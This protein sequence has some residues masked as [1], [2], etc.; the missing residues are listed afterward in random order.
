MSNKK[1]Q[2]IPTIKVTLI[3]KESKLKVLHI[4]TKVIHD[5]ETLRAALNRLGVMDYEIVCWV[6]EVLNIFTFE[7][8]QLK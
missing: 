7:S 2:R 3:N 1:P 5:R 6:H 4:D 8:D